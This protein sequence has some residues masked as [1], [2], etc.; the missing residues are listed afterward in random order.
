M[1]ECHEHVWDVL[2]FYFPCGRE[3]EEHT[4]S[5]TGEK[6]FSCQVDDVVFFIHS[7]YV[8]FYFIFNKLLKNILVCSTGD[9][10]FVF[11]W[12][13][14]L[15]WL[16]AI[17]SETSLNSSTDTPAVI[18]EAPGQRV[19]Y[20]RVCVKN[21]C[22][23]DEFNVLLSAMVWSR[24]YAHHTSLLHTLHTCTKKT[25]LLLTGDS[26]IAQRVL[27]YVWLELTTLFLMLKLQ[28]VT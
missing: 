25:L 19:R 7:L 10:S 11:E 6:C 4:E 3:T 13:L 21:S 18:N 24:D 12:T 8:Y 28:S 20:I 27:A 17:S 2:W 9:T 14:S 26:F 23:K 22:I 1:E 15:N 5:F 16:Q